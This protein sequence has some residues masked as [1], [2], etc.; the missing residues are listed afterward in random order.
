M[1]QKYKLGEKILIEG[2][3]V[4]IELAGEEIVYYCDE[5]PNVPIRQRDIFRSRKGYFGEEIVVR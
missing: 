3:I 4:R 5:A 1:E 2:R